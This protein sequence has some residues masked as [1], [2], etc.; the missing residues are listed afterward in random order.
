M[1]N[2]QRNLPKGENQKKSL[3]VNYWKVKRKLGLGKR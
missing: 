1:V 2:G 3:K